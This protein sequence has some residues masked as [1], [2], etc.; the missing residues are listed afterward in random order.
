M[1]QSIHWETV[2][3]LL[4]SG[5]EQLMDEPL[6]APF[7]LVGGT[8][9]SLQLGHRISI[10]ID[11]F[12]DAPYGSIDFMEI[13]AYL[14]KS[15]NYVFPAALP[16]IVGMGV[17]YIVGNSAE[18]AFKLDLYY[19]DTFVRDAVEAGNI[20]MA[21]LEEIAAMKMDIVQRKGRKKDFWDIHEL[22]DTYSISEMI[23]FHKQRYPHNHDEVLIRQNLTDF[24]GAD[25]DFDPECLK[26][27]AWE[28][29][30]LEIAELAFS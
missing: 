24:T 20:R 1:A 9:L 17:S 25:E 15:F 11:L 2:N 12:T 10:D 3:D 4:K 18:D 23:G 28:L 6:F 19:T 29:V 21:S 22:S 13:D 27:K 16:T 5:L 8:S 7:R 30:K 14:R 26:G